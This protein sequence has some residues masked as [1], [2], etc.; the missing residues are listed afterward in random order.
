MANATPKMTKT[1]KFWK[2]ECAPEC[3][4]QVRDDDQDELAMFANLHSTRAHNK[5]YT[6]E[7]A[8]A[9]MRPA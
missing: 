7:D 1:R 6:R 5:P 4:F 9:I 8:I 3:G 2:I